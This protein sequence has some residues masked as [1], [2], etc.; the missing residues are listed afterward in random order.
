MQA[1][2]DASY[3]ANGRCLRCDIREACGGECMIHSYYASEA[4]SGTGSLAADFPYCAMTGDLMRRLR[5]DLPVQ[6]TDGLR[7]IECT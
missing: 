7:Y 3:T 6:K 2:R 4:A 5:V 1:V